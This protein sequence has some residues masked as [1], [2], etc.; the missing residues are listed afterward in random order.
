MTR[1]FLVVGGLSALV[2]CSDSIAG[3]DASIDDGGASTEGGSTSQDDGGARDA[4]TE[5]GA[6]PRTDGGGS[7]GKCGDLAS[8][9]AMLASLGGGID[10][11]VAASGG[12]MA[13]AF[14][15]TY[16]I[17]IA[18][19]QARVLVEQMTPTRS[20]P[21]QGY[22]WAYSAPPDT[23][24][25]ETN[26]VNVLFESSPGTRAVFQ[27]ELATGAITLAISDKATP[28]SFVRLTGKSPK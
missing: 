23:F 12:T 21:Y 3:A 26:E 16:R 27:C 11:T 14:T 15:G 24:A 7:G 9:Q 19:A 22:V 2:A 8:A 25:V 20:A 13:S 28:T 18:G 5:D 17:F 4:R 6:A 10:A 1:S